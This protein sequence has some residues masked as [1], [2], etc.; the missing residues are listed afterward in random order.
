[1]IHYRKH[2][3]GRGFAKVDTDEGSLIQ[4]SLWQARAHLS[5]SI[6]EE[7]IE[8]V[9]KDDEAYRDSTEEEF[10]RAKS[11]AEAFINLKNI[12]KQ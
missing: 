6:S 1:M 9:M 8:G 7:L 3:S 2:K 5:K 12:N 4:I 11:E 10:S